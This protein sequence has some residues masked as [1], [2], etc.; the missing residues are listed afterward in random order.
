[1]AC[2]S[3]CTNNPPTV[4][5]GSYVKQ[6]GAVNFEAVYSC[7][8]GFRLDGSNIILCQ[9]ALSGWETAPTCTAGRHPSI[10]GNNKRRSDCL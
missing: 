1:M 4:T 8:A 5:D 7:N 10:N 6:E 2:I 9:S 3:D